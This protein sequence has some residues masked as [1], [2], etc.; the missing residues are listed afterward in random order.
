ML[1]L[2]LHSQCK[3]RMRA[4]HALVVSNQWN[5]CNG[6]FPLAIYGMNANIKQQRWL[7]VTNFDAADERG[8]LF[9][10]KNL[11]V[12]INIYVIFSLTIAVLHLLF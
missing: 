6:V 8:L 9:I 4:L 5:S 3:C 7:P 2:D 12:A 11:V 1:N 10:G